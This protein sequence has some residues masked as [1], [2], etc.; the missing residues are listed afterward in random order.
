VE[1]NK[2]RWKKQHFYFQSFSFLYMIAKCQ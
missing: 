2:V 1:N